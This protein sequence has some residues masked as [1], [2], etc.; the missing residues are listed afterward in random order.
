MTLQSDITQETWAESD[1]IM[2]YLN[3]QDR[4]E[5][6]PD[7]SYVSDAPV[8]LEHRMK[9]LYIYIYIYI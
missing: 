1:V 5:E 2:R 9:R 6:V 3:E 8:H 7:D 4:K